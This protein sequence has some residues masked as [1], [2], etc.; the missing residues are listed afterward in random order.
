MVHHGFFVLVLVL[1]MLKRLPEYWPI[2]IAKFPGVHPADREMR[3][4]SSTS[5]RTICLRRDRTVDL[6]LTDSALTGAP[7][8]GTNP[9][10]LNSLWEVLLHGA[11]PQPVL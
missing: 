1:E 8:N 7:G 2:P 5:T 6:S 11:S 3:F 10:M 4:E 9:V